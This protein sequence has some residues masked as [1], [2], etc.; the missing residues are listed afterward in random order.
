MLN[1]VT[2]FVRRNS[3]G[4]DRR[5]VVN[6]ARKTKLFLCRVVMVAKEAVHLDHIDVV[7]LRGLQNLSRALPA[8]DV[9]RSAHFPPTI[10]RTGHPNLRPDA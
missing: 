1:C 4:R 8:G 6:V 7:N 9:G 2:C 5:R 10:E 3:Q